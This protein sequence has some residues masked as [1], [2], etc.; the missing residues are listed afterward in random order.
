MSLIGYISIIILYH[1]TAIPT[2]GVPAYL[3]W[4]VKFLKWRSNSGKK[5]Q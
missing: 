5:Q 4:N 3:Y 2:I 1:I